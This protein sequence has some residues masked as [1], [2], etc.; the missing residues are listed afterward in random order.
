MGEGDGARV[1]KGCCV[2]QGET[3]PVVEGVPLPLPCNGVTVPPPPTTPT[4]LC[5]VEVMVGECVRVLEAGGVDVG[6]VDPVK[7]PP[8][9]EEEVWVVVRVLV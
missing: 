4:P 6:V 3:Q 1:G 5:P 2:M 9:V 7:L 8:P